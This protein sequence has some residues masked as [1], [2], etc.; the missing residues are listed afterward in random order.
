M[1]INYLN[2]KIIFMNWPVI[3]F[4]GLA[5]IA[6]IVFLVIRNQKDEKDFEQQLN[7]DF[8]KTKDVEKDIEIKEGNL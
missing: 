7:N 2:S 1:G 3:I 8:H 6:L 5:A 4:F